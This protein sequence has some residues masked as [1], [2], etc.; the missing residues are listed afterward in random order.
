MYSQPDEKGYFKEGD[1]AFGGRF[2]PETLMY[3]LEELEYFYK[4]LKDD[5]SFKNQLNYYLK[6]YAGRP[7]PLYFAQKLSDLAGAKI[8]LKREDLLHTGA[9]KINNAIGQCLL[10]K[11]MGKHRIIAET[12]AGQ[13]GV[14]TAT[15][16]ALLGLECVVYMGEEDVRR[17]RLNVF[18][19]ELLGAKVEVVTS[20][21]KTL[22][23]AIN[24]ALRDW[25]TNVE[26]THYVVGSVVGPHPFPMIVRDFQK[27]IGEE[28]KSQII[29][30]EGRLPDFVIACVGGGSNSIGI[31]YPFIDDKEVKLIGVEAGGLGLASKKHAAPLSDGEVGI[32]HGMKSYFMQDEE[33]QILG[34]HSVSA[35]LDYPGVGPEHAFLKATKRATYIYA[36]DEEALEGF[37]LLAKT[38]GI[39]PALESS[40]AVIKAIDI[41]KENPGSLMIINLSGRGDKDVNQ[42]FD[43]FKG[44]I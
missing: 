5:E 15:A 39:I 7:T 21:T 11:K 3:A 35:G 10:A 40:H 6:D 43:M 26:T 30:K 13:H 38:E 9:H 44:G 22:K 16:C 4:K 32:L 31:F 8:Y 36:T 14:A 37:K 19:M 2:L 27:V 29:E 34:T 28:T 1:I 17:Q 12:G 18:R 24:E 33:G 23:D 25:V 20:G 42:I 41:A